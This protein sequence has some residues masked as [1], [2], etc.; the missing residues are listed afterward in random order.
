MLWLFLTACT[1][2]SGSP[3]GPGAVDVPDT[4]AGTPSLQ[5]GAAINLARQQNLLSSLNLPP[6]SRPGEI[7]ELH[8]CDDTLT[9][10]KVKGKVAE[11]RTA[12]PI[13]YSGTSTALMEI[14]APD[15]T[16][17]ER[18]TR[19]KMTRGSWRATQGAVILR[20][21]DAGETIPAGECQIKATHSAGIEASL[22][23]ETSGK[24]P[25]EFAFRS[26]DEGNVVRTG[27]YL[28]APGGISWNLSLPAGA[29]FET[30]GLILAP[31]LPLPGGSDGASLIVSVAVGGETIEAGRQ[32]IPASGEE[33]V[34]I[35]LSKWGGQDVTL[36]LASEPGASSDLD[37]LFLTEPAV[38]TPRADPERIVVLFIDT[39]RPDHLGYYGYERDTSPAL[40]A[41]SE[42]AA[43]FSQARGTSSWTLPSSQSALSGLQPEDWGSQ[44]HLAEALSSAGFLTAAN[45][46]NVNL[47]PAYNMG[48]GW[49]RYTYGADTNGQRT[50]DAGLAF[51]KENAD[52]DV[53]LMLHFVEPHLPYQEPEAYRSLWAGPLPAGLPADFK[54][55]SLLGKALRNMDGDQEAIKRYVED[56]YD[57][58]IRYLDD[59]LKRLLTTLDE[60]DTVVLFSDHGEE[61]WEHGGFEHGHTVYDEVVRVVMSVSGPGIVAGDIDA[62]VSLLDLTPTV[63]ELAGLPAGE[64]TGISLVPAA[65]RDEATLSA[66]RARPQSFGRLLHSTDAWGTLVDG[67]KWISRDSKDTLFDIAADPGEQENI[68]AGVSLSPYHE[69]MSEALGVDVA[70]AWR[71]TVVGGVLPDDTT[72]TISHP[73]GFSKAWLG[74][75][76]RGRRQPINHLVDGVFTIDHQGG[77]LLPLS[78][79]LLPTGGEGSDPTGLTLT[80]GGE[81]TIVGGDKGKA[82]LLRVKIGSVKLIISRDVVPVPSHEHTV[83]G[84]AGVE[85][86][87]RA[88]GYIE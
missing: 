72:I 60:D 16:V 68:A 76:P 10:I 13:R 57:Q 29:V 44:P 38:F 77:A 49:S 55:F 30:T 61:F 73:G 80:V 12:L 5:T 78:T 3:D 87:L 40:D 32:A 15:G 26:I 63:L 11:Y 35:D 14:T 45:V 52:R 75:D 85:D 33:K 66:L 67:H 50:V 21:K 64:R 59:Q 17:L 42:G 79:Y 7:P 86:A 71:L 25:V 51:L 70:E 88:L 2:Q 58:N 37:Y 22:N 41:W 8:A 34:R 23:L 36:M 47:T 19:G 56:R 83:Y 39:L 81:S 69:A 62:P 9:R 65:A 43:R 84:A 18:D 1:G 54:R 20:L 24:P 48:Y 74:Y 31:E 4:P 28:P 27:V 6:R 53:A 46:A 82:E